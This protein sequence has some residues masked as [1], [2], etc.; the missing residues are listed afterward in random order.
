MYQFLNRENVSLHN[1]KTITK[2]EIEDKIGFT[3]RKICVMENPCW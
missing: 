3:N 2:Q 1:T